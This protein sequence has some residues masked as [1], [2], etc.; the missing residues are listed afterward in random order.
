MSG[1]LTMRT[2]ARRTVRAVTRTVGRL[3]HGHRLRP[4][5]LVVGAQR[6]GTTTMMKTLGQHP[7]VLPAVFHKG[8]H[9]FDV[10]HH[11]GMAWYAGHFPAA[12][13]GV[14]TGE[15]SPYYM[16]HP[17]APARIAAELP[18]VRLIVLLRDPVERAYS[19]YTHER[20]R[21][22]E[23]EEFGR[24]LELE[25]SRLA[26]EVERLRADPGYDSPHW[27]HN[28]Y[29][30]RGQYVE[31]LEHLE[32]LFGRDRLCV[33]DSHD[34]FAEPEWAFRAVEQFL[35]LPHADGIEYERHNA[36]PRSPMSPELRARLDDHFRPYDER[37]ADWWGRTP[38]WRR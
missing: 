30:T 15:S 38:S 33:V 22:Y 27:R 6:C 7:G 11:R 28:A 9:Y 20:A 5:F 21:G 29:V 19:A 26:G 13:A 1:P 32:S 18:G 23:T 2:R 3:T 25:P 36:R 14:L 17:V 12:K 8:V 24:A 37:L 4:A 16:F 10:N 31:Q 35:G 34:F